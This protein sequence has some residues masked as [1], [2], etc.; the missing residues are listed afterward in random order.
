MLKISSIWDILKK[1]L[2]KMTMKLSVSEEILQFQQLILYV[3]F[4]TAQ[5][6]LSVTHSVPI[7]ISY[8]CM[9]AYRLRVYYN[10]TMRQLIV[11]APWFSASNVFVSLDVRSVHETRRFLNHSLHKQVNVDSIGVIER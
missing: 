4:L 2:S 3:N 9:C 5:M 7:A 8:V 6:K 11:L 10:K 1:L